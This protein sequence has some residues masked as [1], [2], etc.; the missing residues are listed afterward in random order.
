MTAKSIFYHRTT[1]QAVATLPLHHLRQ[2]SNTCCP[3][4]AV[5]QSPSMVQSR[6]RTHP[7]TP[8]TQAAARKNIHISKPTPLRERHLTSTTDSVQFFKQRKNHTMRLRNALSRPSYNPLTRVLFDTSPSFNTEFSFTDTSSPEPSGAD[9]K[10]FFSH[11]H[12]MH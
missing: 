5:K 6:C 10:S 12:A 9:P 1:V 3:R 11:S 7:Y 4:R 2:Q 8:I